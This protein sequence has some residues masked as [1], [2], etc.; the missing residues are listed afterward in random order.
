MDGIRT[1]L[2]VNGWLSLLFIKEQWTGKKTKQVLGQCD[3]NERKQ[4]DFPDSN[5]VHPTCR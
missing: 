2:L 5:K 1:F 4:Q 3:F